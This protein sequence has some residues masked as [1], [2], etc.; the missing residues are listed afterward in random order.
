MPDEPAAPFGQQDAPLVAGQDVRPGRGRGPFRQHIDPVAAGQ[1]AAE[2][3]VQ[4]PLLGRKQGFAHIH[5]PGRRARRAIH[6]L[7][8]P[9]DLPF[10]VLPA[11]EYAGR[12]AQDRLPTLAVQRRAVH[13]PCAARLTQPVPQRGSLQLG[14]DHVPHGP[15]IAALAVVQQDQVRLHSHDVIERMG[16]K[17]RTRG[18]GLRRIGQPQGQDGSVAGDAQ[19]PQLLPALSCRG[20]AQVLRL[21][22]QLPVQQ[23]RCEPLQG[24][25]RRAVQ[26]DEVHHG[27]GAGGGQPRRPLGQRLVQAALK[28]RRSI[29]RLLQKRHCEVKA[30]RPAGIERQAHPQRARRIE[31]RAHGVRQPRGD[32]ARPAR[33]P[34]AP[35]QLF[36]V[37]LAADPALRPDHVDEHRAALPGLSGSSP[38]SQRAAGEPLALHKEPLEDGMGP[39][40]GGGGQRHR[41]GVGDFRLQRR[42]PFV[43]HR[44]RLHK[45]AVLRGNAQRHFHPQRPTFAFKSRRSHVKAA[46]PALAADHVIL[47]GAHMHAGAVAAVQEIPVEARAL[48]APG[49][50]VER[51]V[52]RDQRRRVRA[53]KQMGIGGMA[54]GARHAPAA[55]RGACRRGKA[56]LPAGIE[57]GAGKGLLLQQQGKGAC[58]GHGHEVGAERPLRQRVAKRAQDHALVMGH[59]AFD[60]RGHAVRVRPQ[61]IRG[62]EEPPGT[63]PAPLAHILDI[64]RRRTGIDGQRQRGGVGR[65]HILAH[66]AAQRQRLEAKGAVLVIQMRVKG[67]VARFGHAPRTLPD[68]AQTPLRAHRA[69]NALPQQRKRR[70]GHDQLGHQIFKHRAAPGQERRALPHARAGAA[71]MRP[72][73]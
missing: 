7:Q 36:I 8:Q 42:L 34:H 59:V 22:G 37:R 9:P 64:P 23:E 29:L 20:A 44:Q 49:E 18:I 2:A 21:G 46:A 43:F 40:V 61:V 67:G 33:V 65:D 53:A 16:A 31:R 41:R 25:V 51:A 32:A 15:G 55:L 73:G 72:V 26:A 50:K 63:R 30:R 17:Q 6:R 66:A 68:R 28:P 19:R 56:G 45:S 35:G 70:R 54:V 5:P 12:R 62:L 52:R 58:L 71:Q 14:G 24:M 39:H 13:D 60:Q 48:H 11:L 47:S 3:V 69:P 1:E 27:P 57:P 38:E 4:P 10:D